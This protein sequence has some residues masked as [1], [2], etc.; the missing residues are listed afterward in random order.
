M[1]LQAL[2]KHLKAK[3]KKTGTAFLLRPFTACSMAEN[4]SI[5]GSLVRQPGSVLIDYQMEGALD[6]ISW[7]KT[8]S[9]TGRCHELWRQTCFELFFSIKD[10][11][12]YWEVNLCRNDCWNVYHFTNYRT[13]MREERAIGQPVFRFVTD[14]DLL[15][16][17]CVLE[18]NGLIDDLSDLEVGVSSVIQAADGSTSY[19]AIEHQGLVPD[20]HNRPSFCLGLPGITKI[21]N[22]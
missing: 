15:S 12:A 22:N 7:S 4:L 20:F 14:G 8:S 18:L 2:N 11:A 21:E 16:L 17:T 5:T 13:G 19:W 9:V 10:E 1:G 6:R 3:N